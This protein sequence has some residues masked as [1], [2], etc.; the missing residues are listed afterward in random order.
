MPERMDWFAERVVDWS[1]D[2][3]RKDLPWQLNRSAYATWVSE[4]ML[5]Q[6][7]VAT[8]IPYFERF[9]DR[10]PDVHALARA[11]IDEVLHAWTGLGYYARGRNLHKAARQ[12]VADHAGFD[13]APVEGRGGMEMGPDAA[14]LQRLRFQ[15]E[16]Q[17]H[18]I[19]RN[20][21]VE[22]ISNHIH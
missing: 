20:G 21:V 15:L 2:Y 22:V 5:Q 7:Q 16:V 12:I 14:Q 19:D 13:H 8:V 3:G 1:D 4:I 9:T 18:R 11:E 17:L 10:F 6:T